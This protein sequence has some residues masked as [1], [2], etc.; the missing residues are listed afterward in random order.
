MGDICSSDRDRW[1]EVSVRGGDTIDYIDVLHNNQ[2]IHRECLTPCHHHDNIHKVYFEAGW[3][4]GNESVSW[5][6][7]LSV[8]DGELLKVEPRFRGYGPIDN[9]ENEDMA[10]TSWEWIEPN[11]VNFRTHTRQNPSIHTAATEGISLEMITNEKTRLLASV[12]GQ[13]YEQPVSELITGTR[14]HYLGGFVSPAFCFHRAVPQSEY[15]HCFK[16]L[17]QNEPDKRDWYYVRVRQINGQW[18][19]SSPIWVEK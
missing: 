1:I 5:D 15:K 7:K 11:Q 3:G 9:I 8:L 12:N 4:E 18:A 10:Y 2:V 17:H 14:T 16:F 19:W 6:V 13:Q